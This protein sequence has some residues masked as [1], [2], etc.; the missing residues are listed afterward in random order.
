MIGELLV[1]IT[2]QHRVER[3]E[4]NKDTSVVIVLRA[5][6]L[7]G[8]LSLSSRYVLFSGRRRSEGQA[9]FVGRVAK[10]NFAPNL[11]R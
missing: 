11:I 10:Y 7:A 3:T 9:P 6:V 4:T 8:G 5:A 2:M 1:R